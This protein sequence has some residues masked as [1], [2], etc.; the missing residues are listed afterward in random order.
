MANGSFELPD[1]TPRER[2]IRKLARQLH[3]R[4]HGDPLGKYAYAECG[5]DWHTEKWFMYAATAAYDATSKGR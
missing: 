4:E 2:A 1:V 3:A 5:E